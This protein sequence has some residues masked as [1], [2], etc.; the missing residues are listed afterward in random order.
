MEVSAFCLS[1]CSVHFISKHG[2]QSA[3]CSSLLP[4]GLT[5]VHIHIFY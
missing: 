1:V 2:Q 5:D 3:D 4:H